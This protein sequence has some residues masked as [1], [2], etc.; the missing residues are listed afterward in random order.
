MENGFIFAQNHGDEPGTDRPDP[1]L[2]DQIMEVFSK[3]SLYRSSNMSMNGKQLSWL[4]SFYAAMIESNY[5]CDLLLRHYG[6]VNHP[7]IAVADDLRIRSETLLFLMRTAQTLPDFKRIWE[8][9]I[10]REQHLDFFRH[11]FLRILK[12][13]R[14]I[15]NILGEKPDK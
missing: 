11:Y 5:R 6:S 13:K 4:Q 12:A 9:G 14:I 10:S 7:L 1:H 2:M 3:S 8:N 15:R